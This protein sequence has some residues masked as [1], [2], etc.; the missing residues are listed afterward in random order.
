MN[1]K[2]FVL[3][4]IFF[5]DTNLEYENLKKYFKF[6]TSLSCSRYR[7]KYVLLLICFTL[8]SFEIRVVGRR[9]LAWI[10]TME[11]DERVINFLF[12]LL[13]IY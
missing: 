2:V 9:G 10:P 6:H 1:E 3:F 13:P 8:R 7:E 5:I 4:F 12:K 11:N